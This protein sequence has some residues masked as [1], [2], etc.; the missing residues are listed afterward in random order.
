MVSSLYDISCIVLLMLLH[1]NKRWSFYENSYVCNH[2]SLYIKYPICI[3][4][5]HSHNFTSHQ[6]PLKVEVLAY[7]R[8]LFCFVFFTLTRFSTLSQ[9]LTSCLF[10][11]LSL[12]GILTSVFSGHIQSS[13]VCK[14]TFSGDN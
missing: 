4:F 11:S 2:P 7:P 1:G 10:W 5:C 6:K 14:I 12:V 3:F 8:F 13:F 9:F